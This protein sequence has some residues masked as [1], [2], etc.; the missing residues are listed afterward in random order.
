MAARLA[1]T[2]K[3]KPARVRF[4][5][6]PEGART[7]K[8]KA[9]AAIA[10]GDGGW[11]EAPDEWRAPFL[12]AAAAEWASYPPLEDLFSF[13]PTALRAIVPRSQ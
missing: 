1:A 6:L 8:F 10:L 7:D 11:L 4:R 3:D 5:S 13:L 12:P 2:D 9:I